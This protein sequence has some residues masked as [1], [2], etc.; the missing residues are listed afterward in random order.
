[1]SERNKCLKEALDRG[2]LVKDFLKINDITIMIDFVGNRKEN[3][4]HYSFDAE[5][6]SGGR[7]SLE[8]ARLLLAHYEC[9]TDADFQFWSGDHRYV[10]KVAKVKFDF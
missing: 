3:P 9:Y 8:E 7:F 5:R 1:M 2:F 10:F 4:E 6:S